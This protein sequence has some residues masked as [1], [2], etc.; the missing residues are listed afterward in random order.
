MFDTMGK[1]TWK[2]RQNSA[3]FV[4]GKSPVDTALF[5]PPDL[6]VEQIIQIGTLL[7]VNFTILEGFKTYS[8]PR[9][10]CARSVEEIEEWLNEKIVCIAGPISKK[11]EKYKGIPII[12]PLIH[13]NLLMDTVLAYSGYK[14]LWVS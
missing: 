8:C 1:D 2:Y 6:P 3:D 13:P 14:Q 11:L 12:D 4:V 5:L 9:I 7:R 10:I